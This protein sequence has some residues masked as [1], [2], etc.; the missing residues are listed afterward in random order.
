MFPH[1]QIG[2]PG[3]QGPP[4]PMGPPGPA[5]AVLTKEEILTEFRTIIRG[6]LRLERAPKLNITIAYTKMTKPN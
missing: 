4:G 2:L 6:M 1:F 5:G 3:A